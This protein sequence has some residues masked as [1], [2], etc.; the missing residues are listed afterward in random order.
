MRKTPGRI[1]EEYLN[2]DDQC[3]S[4]VYQNKMFSILKNMFQKKLGFFKLQQLLGLILPYNLYAQYM[5][6][7][8]I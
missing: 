1:I 4:Q 6:Y 7:T 3:F 8:S 5:Q 2:P